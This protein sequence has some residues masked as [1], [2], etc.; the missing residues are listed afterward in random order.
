MRRTIFIIISVSFFLGL[1]SCSNTPDKLLRIQENGLYGFVDTLG[2]V[3]I[4]PQ[5]KYCGDFSKDGYAL[6]ISKAQILN[7]T[8]EIKYGF[9][10]TNN[11][12]VVDTIHD[13]K[14]AIPELGSLWKMYDAETFVNKYNS[15]GL[16]FMDSYFATLR[17]SQG[18][19][20]YINSNNLI[21]YKNLKGEIAISAKY[22]YAGPFVENVAIVSEGITLDPNKS[23]SDNLNTF[24][25][26]NN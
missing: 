8:L 19:Y 12:L 24:S 26:I 22:K 20:Q 25:I 18:L 21:G 5:Y 1:I 2:N 6:I 9:I 4:E 13:L 11:K 7:D 14:I 10:D 3:K 17:V 23:M 15:S 16:G